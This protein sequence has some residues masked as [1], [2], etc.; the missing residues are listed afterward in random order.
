M[1]PNPVPRQDEALSPPV[2]PRSHPLLAALSD[3]SAS[4][5]LSEIKSADGRSV[6]NP[7]AFTPTKGNKSSAH[8]DWYDAFQ[9]PFDQARNGYDLHIYF[10]PFE[11]G[12]PYDQLPPEAQWAVALRER[13]RKEFPELR[14]YRFWHRPIGPHTKGMFEVNVFTPQQLGGLLAFLTI[15]RG[16]VH[17]SSSPASL[18]AP[19]RWCRR[20]ASATDGLPQKADG[21]RLALT[22]LT[23]VCV[24]EY[25]CACRPLS[26]LIHPNTGA[27][28]ACWMRPSPGCV[29]WRVNAG[30]PRSRG[31]AR[32]LLRY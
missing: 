12:T 3:A 11:E 31:M 21:R 22:R 32:S 25:V 9:A 2:A 14:V 18:K 27:Y 24:C 13:I 6:L 10:T 15:N 7:S 5:P 29:C 19:P 16:Y 20:P 30:R 26:I 23:I 17:L 28:D 8:S 1:A 4:Q